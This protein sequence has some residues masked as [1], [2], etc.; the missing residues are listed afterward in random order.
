MSNKDPRNNR[1]NHQTK[2]V[3]IR[4]EVWAAW[5]RENLNGFP[6]RTLLGRMTDGELPGFSSRPP[7][8]MPEAV[9]LT[10]RAVAKLD[11]HR[12]QVIREYYGNWA[13][14]EVVAKRLNLSLGTF[15]TRLDD[16]RRNIHCYLEILEDSFDARMGMC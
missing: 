3:H 9:A 8:S 7:I 10:D 1:M 2:L 11:T 5:S 6:A 15:R 12:Q 16:A 14:P 13:P 4:L